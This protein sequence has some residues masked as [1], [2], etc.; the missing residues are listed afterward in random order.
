MLV[1]SQGLVRFL[2]PFASW[3]RPG[4]LA[5]LERFLGRLGYVLSCSGPSWAILR[6]S[7][8]VFGTFW[9]RL[10]V[11]LEDNKHWFSLCFLGVLLLGI[12]RKRIS[13]RIL[14]G[15][16]LRK[17]FGCISRVCWFALL[18]PLS[19]AWALLAAVE[20]EPCWVHYR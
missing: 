10:G 12:P 13:G 16:H 11:V 17:C 3:D 2:L 20:C 8:A 1:A 7:W 15:L 18:G 4:R 6:S 9:G 19:V 5:L 14:V